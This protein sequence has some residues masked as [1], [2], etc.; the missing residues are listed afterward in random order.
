M[1]EELEIPESAFEIKANYFERPDPELVKFIRKFIGQFGTPHLW[2]GHTHTKPQPGSRVTFLAKYTLPETHRRRA[3]WAPCPC[4][5]LRYPKY[6]RQGLI[7]W[8]PTEGVIRCVGDKCYKKMDPEGYALAMKQL[9]D[10]IASDRRSSFLLSRVPQ[11][12]A[13][14][15]LIERSLPTVA[16]IDA[17]CRDVRYTLLQRLN[18]DVWH[19]VRD[20]FLRVPTTRPESM[21][22]LDGDLV[23]MLSY[24]DYARID[25]GLALKPSD[26]RLAAELEL[27]MRNLKDLAE[28]MKPVETM[29]EKEKSKAAEIISW[30]HAGAK[31]RLADAIEMRRFF[32][33]ATIATMNSWAKHENAPYRMHFKMDDENFYIGRDETSHFAI[34]WPEHFWLHLNEL[35]PLTKSLAA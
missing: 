21:R 18:L 34:P 1:A 31:K 11:I 32:S 22:S 24:A 25:G 10:E 7:A 14:V 35:D 5:S 9:N 15:R 33:K 13:C 23:H 19:Q 30:A 16:A 6:F 12:P 3:K 2:W 29:T 27:R 17:L 28:G 26:A 20:G 8:F 4:C